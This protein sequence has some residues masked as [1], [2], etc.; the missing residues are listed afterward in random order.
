MEKYQLRYMTLSNS[1]IIHTFFSPTMNVIHT[2]EIKEDIQE[3]TKLI[4]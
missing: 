1:A 2:I 3:D 4:C